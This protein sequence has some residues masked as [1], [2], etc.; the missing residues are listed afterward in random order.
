MHVI[1]LTG[2]QYHV[3]IIII[4]CVA[5]SQC[6]VKS[7]SMQHHTQSIRVTVVHK[8]DHVAVVIKQRCC[9]NTEGE[10]CVSNRPD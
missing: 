5:P 3:T 1:A 6:N 9:T 8:L 4:P 2:V 10:A 7:R